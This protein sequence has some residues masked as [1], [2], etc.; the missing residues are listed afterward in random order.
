MAYDLLHLLVYLVIVIIFI[1]ILL[2]V[3]DRFLLLSAGMG[4]DYA[5]A[6]AL[7]SLKPY[8]TNAVIS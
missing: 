5:V 3:V 4:M 7:G 2:W 8:V 6:Q 1:V